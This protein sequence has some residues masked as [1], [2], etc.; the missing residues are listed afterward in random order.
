MSVARVVGVLGVV[1]LAAAAAGPVRA[2]HTPPPPAFKLFSVLTSA[3]EPSLVA[4]S[5]STLDP[6]VPENH[7]ALATSVMRQ[8][9]AALR[10]AFD[11]LVLYGY[12][13]AST[14]RIV[15]VA[16]S[17]GYRVVVLGV[18]DPRSAAELDGVADLAVMYHQELA[19][20]IVIGNEGLTF[21]RYEP[22]DLVIA[23]QRLRR[24]IPAE[25][26]LA[27]TEPFEAYS[28][29]FLRGFGDFSAPNIHPVFDR[30]ALGP[31]RPRPGCGAQPRHWQHALTGPWLS[32]VGLP[33]GGGEKFSPTKQ[34]EFWSEY[35]RPGLL[36]RSAEDRKAWSY[37][38]VAFEAIDLDW[39]ARGAAPESSIERCW[40]LMSASREPYPAFRIWAE[41]H[42]RSR[43]DGP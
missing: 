37:V 19:I 8:D 1:L 21:K 25:V 29:E 42:Q 26:P 36:I 43:R 38:G 40:G 23:A 13:E 7:R 10:G 28:D 20:G 3:P 33:H 18:W 14:P 15:S 9:L 4:Y 32:G 35:L 17:L 2:Q 31:R 6:G 30:P 39:K 24:K 11:G 41:V 22:E 16:H 27:T 12:Q 34:A 5:L